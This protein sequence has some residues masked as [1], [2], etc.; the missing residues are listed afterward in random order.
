MPANL[1]MVRLITALK[2]KQ[3]C[4]IFDLS[5]WDVDLVMFLAYSSDIK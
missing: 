1:E 5:L 3:N 4:H 2:T